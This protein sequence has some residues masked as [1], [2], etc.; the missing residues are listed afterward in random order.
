MLHK[1]LRLCTCD[2]TVVVAPPTPRTAVGSTTRDGWPLGWSL[3]AL[4]REA[5][6]WELVDA[7]DERLPLRGTT[8]SNQARTRT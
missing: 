4:L 7:V 1:E 6:L 3:A 5:T 8:A 2:S